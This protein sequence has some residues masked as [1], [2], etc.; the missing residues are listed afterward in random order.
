MHII[1]MAAT[2]IMTESTTHPRSEYRKT[3]RPVL[4]S[5]YIRDIGAASA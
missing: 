3:K 5:K 1:D 2:A 4:H